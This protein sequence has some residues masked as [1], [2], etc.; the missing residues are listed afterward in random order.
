[1]LKRTIKFQIQYLTQMCA[2]GKPV[3]PSVGHNLFSHDPSGS[4]GATT[5]D[6]L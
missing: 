1:M 2:N 6:F 5:K 3:F 4:A